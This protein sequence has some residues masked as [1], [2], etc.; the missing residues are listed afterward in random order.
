[1]NYNCIVN[2]Q[3][4]PKITQYMRENGAK[5]GNRVQESVE[6]G[7]K[8][9]RTFVDKAGKEIAN[10]TTTIT[11]AGEKRS[12]TTT[13]ATVNGMSKDTNHD[14]K[15]FNGYLYNDNI[16]TLLPYE[17]ATRHTIKNADGLVAQESIRNF[18]LDTAPLEK[19]KAKDGMKSFVMKGL[20]NN[21]LKLIKEGNI[22][23]YLH[24]TEQGIPIRGYS[25]NAV[26]SVPV[27][28][29]NGKHSTLWTSEDFGP[30]K[31]IGKKPARMTPLDE[32]D[33]N[34]VG[35]GITLS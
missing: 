34:I 1:M 7:K 10:S 21:D 32:G 28:N 5:L 9:T 24:F 14:L 4:V 23:E 2:P 35:D 33:M 12:I 8:I 30:V 15:L 31:E 19:A 29:N 18:K 26:K 25:R 13:L 20:T 11:Q 27:Q 16:K 3:Y 17:A 22:L 6:G